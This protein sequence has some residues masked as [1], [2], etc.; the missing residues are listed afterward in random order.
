[1]SLMVRQL[2]RRL[3]FTQA[4]QNPLCPILQLPIE[5]ILLIFGHLPQYQRIILAQT[6]SSLQ[7]IFINNYKMHKDGWHPLSSNQL[8][9]DQR[10]RFLFT[11]AYHQPNLFGCHLCLKMHS[12]KKRDL[13]GLRDQT[14]AR[15]LQGP[16][17]ALELAIRD[18]FET[19]GGKYGSCS[20]CETDFVVVQASSEKAVV[21]AW[22]H[23]GSETPLLDNQ[24]WK[25][26]TLHAQE[27]LGFYSQP[28]SI[29]RLY[30]TV[31]FQIKNVL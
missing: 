7:N 3:V 12:I 20:Y 24:S 16:R 14:R 11:L 28:T 21:R 30:D 2:L 1:M 22:Q 6:C 5:V 17:G 19:G 4:K 8:G 26:V 29:H 18:S 9:I 25:W 31:P 15:M 27:S 23:L 13:P 10:L